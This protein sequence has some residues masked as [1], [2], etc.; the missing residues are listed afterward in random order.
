MWCIITTD[1][2]YIDGRAYLGW[3]NPVWEESGYFWTSRDVFES[4]LNNSTPE[5]PFLFDSRNEAIKHL[6]SIHIPQMCKVIK[7]IDR[8]EVDAADVGV[9]TKQYTI[10]EVYTDNKKVSRYVNGQ[11]EFSEIMS[12]WEVEGYCRELEN[13]GYYEAYNVE[14]YKEQLESAENEYKWALEAY[15]MAKKSPL[16][17]Q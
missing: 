5:H 2:S 1:E 4:I 10:E 16:I 11:L 15:E 17:T 14:K 3:Q 12:Y 8:V 6:K 7:Y 13:E 9:N